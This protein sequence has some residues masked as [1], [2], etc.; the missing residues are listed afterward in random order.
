M[1]Y[2]AFYDS[3]GC[4]CWQLQIYREWGTAEEGESAQVLAVQ[5]HPE[6]GARLSGQ[7]VQ[8]AAGQRGSAVVPLRRRVFLHHQTPGRQSVNA[9]FNVQLI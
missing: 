5:A 9:N 6:P 8:G 2:W 1:T 7:R 3:T 4:L